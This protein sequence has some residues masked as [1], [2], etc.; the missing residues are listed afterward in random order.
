[1]Y[2]LR[3]GDTVALLPNLYVFDI[4][5]APTAGDADAVAR[6]TANT[7]VTSVAATS[8]TSTTI[9]ATSKRAALPTGVGPA[10]IQ[11]ATVTTTAAAAAEIE[12]EVE[13]PPA[14][15]PAL[16]LAGTSVLRAPGGACMTSGHS[17]WFLAA[18]V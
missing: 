2:R 9:T 14:K 4:A 3:V 17:V 5:R 6:A 1:M 12:V 11:T 7:A 13:P 10:A 15:R 16:R 18:R 8:L